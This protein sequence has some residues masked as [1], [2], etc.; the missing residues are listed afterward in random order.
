MLHQPLLGADSV[1]DVEAGAGKA[2]RHKRS[3]ISLLGE[4]GGRVGGAIGLGLVG[5]VGGAGGIWQHACFM[6]AWLIESRGRRPT[7][8]MFSFFLPSLPLLHAAI[9]ATYM[10]PDS[11]GLRLRAVICVGL[12]VSSSPV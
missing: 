9:A 12:V 5:L 7:C 10:W 4:E 2:A 8:P 1:A 3:W 11:F 6:D